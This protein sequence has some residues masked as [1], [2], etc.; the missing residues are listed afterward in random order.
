VHIKP[1]IRG[2]AQ[3]YTGKLVYGSQDSPQ[4]RVLCC[5]TIIKN[6]ENQTEETKSSFFEHWKR[7][8]LVI[9][10]F[11][12]ICIF[13]GSLHL[14]S[15]QSGA[16]VIAIPLCLFLYFLPAYI[17]FKKE[18]KNKVAIFA[19]NLFLGW[20]LIGWIVALVWSLTYEERK[21]IN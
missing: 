6:M 5:A 10:G 14:S 13:I 16:L 20:T 18:K 15:E 8:V 17:A 11:V 1:V 4:W 19:L 2:C 9:V 7:S 3:R 12:A 21:N